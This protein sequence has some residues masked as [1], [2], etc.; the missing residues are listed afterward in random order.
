[1]A[2]ATARNRRLTRDRPPT[3][4]LSYWEWLRTTPGELRAIAVGL[5]VMLAVIG[6]VV[7]A[8]VDARHRAASAVED[9][10]VPEVV[11]AQDLYRALADANTTASIRYLEGIP[12]PSVRLRKYDADLNAAGSALAALTAE[13][14]ADRRAQNS[15][16]IIIQRLPVFGAAV[17]A[18]RDNSRQGFQL[19]GTYLREAS[20][21]M[22]EEILPEAKALYLRAVDRLNRQFTDGTAAR[23]IRFVVIAGA[24]AALGLVAAQ[25]LVARR[26]RRLLNP[27]LVGA[28]V[29]VAVLMVWTGSRFVSAQDSLVSAQQ[30][31]SDAVQVLSAARILNLEAQT[32]G[33]VALIERDG[34]DVG[35]SNRALARV[36]GTLSEA[37]LVAQRGLSVIPRMDAIVSTYGRLR[38]EHADVRGLDSDGEYNAAVDVAT[39]REAR[40]AGRLD[41]ELNAAIV[42]A[43]GKL[44]TNAADAR[45]GFAMLALAIPT[46]LVVAAALVLIGLS[47]RIKEFR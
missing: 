46:L 40:A 17:Q 42:H 3:Q 47:Q 15:A 34:S 19:G 41:D 25:V 14:P 37:R 31:G 39:R 33:N 45:A 26:S 23:D 28:T 30:Q 9:D 29:A 21:V 13:L 32:A 6:V 43:R 36:G 7:Y 8:A 1:V 22:G 27:G 20:R 18:S 24:V 38:H 44:D 4:D 10:A 5:L 11:A 35:R 12:E 2:T 16:R